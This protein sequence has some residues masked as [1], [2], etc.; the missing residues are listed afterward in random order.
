MRRR[1]AR[2]GQLCTCAI[3]RGLILC[4]LL[5]TALTSTAAPPP[6]ADELRQAEK[7]LGNP[8]FRKRAAAIET[9]RAAGSA[10][11]P[12]LKKL[13]ESD[14]P[15]IA[16]RARE[17]LKDLLPGIRPDTPQPVADLVRA[18]FRETNRGRRSNVIRRLGSIKPF[19]LETVLELSRETED[20]DLR[21]MLRGLISF[22][23]EH[24]F[25]RILA[26]GDFT[27]AARILQIA[28]EN[29][30]TVAQ[31]RLAAVLFLTGKEKEALPALI[32]KAKQSNTPADWM[33]VAALHRI[34]GRIQDARAV[35][36]H[37][38]K[39][40]TGQPQL[41][42]NPT[43]RGIWG[44][45]GFGG[46]APFAGG[47]SFGFG[48]GAMGVGS[49]SLWENILLEAEDWDSYE[50]TVGNY[51]K[52]DA[53]TV[54]VRLAIA[55]AAN[56]NSES[57]QT[58]IQQLK[59]LARKEHGNPNGRIAAQGLLAVDQLEAFRETLESQ[60]DIPYFEAFSDLKQCLKL[61]P[62][63]P[64]NAKPQEIISA[65]LR[66][67]NI[68]HRTGGRDEAKAV[69]ERLWKA[70]GASEHSTPLWYAVG[71]AVAGCGFRQDVLEHVEKRLTQKP[72][73]MKPTGVGM[74]IQGNP[75]YIAFVDSVLST[76]FPWSGF[77]KHVERVTR[78]MAGQTTAEE[79]RALLAKALASPNLEESEIAQFKILG[80]CVTQDVIKD[81]A[82]AAAQWI[83][84]AMDPKLAP[85]RFLIR[86]MTAFAAFEAGDWRVAKQ[87]YERQKQSTE[88]LSSAM[89]GRQPAF[90]SMGQGASPSLAVPTWTLHMM[91]GR[92]W[93]GLLG[94]L[95]AEARKAG[96]DAEADRLLHEARLLAFTDGPAQARLATI[97]ADAG[98]ADSAREQA[99]LA[100]RLASPQ[101]NSRYFPSVVRI[102]AEFA[103][104]K[105]DWARA[106][107]LARWNRLQASCTGTRPRMSQPIPLRAA[108]FQHE[109]EGRAAIAANKPAEAL[110]HFQTALEML[111]SDCDA[112]IRLV[113]F[114]RTGGYD[115]QG[116]ELIDSY[117]RHWVNL[118]KDYP[119]SALMHNNLAWFLANCGRDL[120]KAARLAEKA[121]EL[122]PDTAAY[123]DTL[124]EAHIRLGNKQK[125]AELVQRCLELEPWTEW[126]A[127]QKKRVEAMK[128]KK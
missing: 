4:A 73:V 127:K 77:G 35:F 15:E 1:N 123:L 6:S 65:G 118:L 124:A 31:H 79:W 84:C 26:K 61:V 45:G 88:G 42:A 99:E 107:H 95:S 40:Q 51:A 21:R 3:V 106:V 81:P 39:K 76:V 113:G 44:E 122:E 85:A 5:T 59:Q 66:R 72:W 17:V 91:M 89:P 19:P 117:G 33:Q 67:L 126:F 128:P 82:A 41:K 55:Q 16:V 56:G 54:L 48:L 20:P 23:P 80:A 125:A 36:E 119:Q 27:L 70:A 64:E 92:D 7:D 52:P 9:F 60:V 14:D 28:A 8:S 105:G 68:L 94:R 46:Q 25:R 96:E 11:R 30:N 78:F 69:C 32:E 71:A 115:K 120:D 114:L 116:E 13:A 93:S 29:G 86:R 109:C 18:Y 101:T 12:M 57:L 90:L 10:A 63:P 102:A 110:R 24:F 100:L 2:V 34:A 75:S 74:L 98:F 62:A 43:M 37:I 50:K 47:T 83:E 112:A 22:Q 103:A 38:G 53:P 111:P 87:I 121:V 97:L 58:T 49:H 104:K 108:L